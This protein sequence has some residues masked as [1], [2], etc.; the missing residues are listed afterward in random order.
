MS[1]L[2]KRPWDELSVDFAGPFPTEEYLLIVID[3]FSRFPEVEIVHSITAQT[4][5]FKLNQI[6]ARFGTPSILKSD[7]GAPFNGEYFA[8]F[9]RKLGFTHRKITPLWPEANGEAER[10]VRLL[11][12]FVHTC[13]S[14]SLNWKQ[15]LPD[16]LRQYRAT[17]HS[18]TKISPHEALTARKMKTSLP[19]I[20]SLHQGCKS[21]KNIADNDYSA[22]EKQKAYSDDRRN[23]VQHKIQ[24]G[25][26]VLVRQP[27]LNKLT[28]PY[29]PVPYI[30]TDVK[31]SMITAANAGHTITRNSSFFKIIRSQDSPSQHL[32]PY[33]SPCQHLNPDAEILFNP[34]DCPDGGQEGNTSTD[35]TRMQGELP[36]PPGVI[37]DEALPSRLPSSSQ[38]QTHPY[39]VTRSGR[40]VIPPTRYTP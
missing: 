16:F 17:P 7:N 36:H 15:K 22:K 30:V 39:T 8:S 32:M 2:P 19:E 34:Y 21:A 3:D 6:F 28:P 4:V 11:N 5:T 35:S 23:A 27:K 24:M 40:L 33:D 26:K 25:D 1:P 13:E 14:E 18:S 9:A 12:K 29:N 10:F 20:I 31:G 38:P 37:A